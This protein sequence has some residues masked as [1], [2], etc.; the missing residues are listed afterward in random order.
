[1]P[2]ESFDLETQAELAF[3]TLQAGRNTGKIVL[4]VAARVEEQLRHGGS[5]L[6]SGGTAGLGLLTAR[7]LVQRG[8]R[9]LALASRSG[10]IGAQTSADWETI[11][12]TRPRPATVLAQCDAAQAK[13]LRRLVAHARKLLPPLLGAWHAAGVLTDALLPNQTAAGACAV[14][15]PKACGGWALQQACAAMEL[16]ACTLFSSVSSLLGGAWQTNY[17]AA[18]ACLDGLAVCRRAHGQAAVSVQWGPWGEVGMAAKGSLSSR[19]VAM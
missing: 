19:V 4:R 3:R 5:H 16:R 7:W 2:L 15:A 8:A 6:V 1:M 9:G 18:N 11:C 14:Y 17:S 13:D 12:D 10:K